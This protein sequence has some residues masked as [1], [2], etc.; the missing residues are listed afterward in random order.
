MESFRDIVRARGLARISWMRQHVP[1][2]IRGMVVLSVGLL[3]L[4]GRSIAASET[5]LYSF[6]GGADGS[7]PL[8]GLATD[9]TGTLYGVTPEGG[10]GTACNLSEG[11]GTAFTLTP[12]V[13]SGGVWTEAVI[14][15][16]AGVFGADGFY[17][18]GVP[19]V[20]DGG[21]YGATLQGGTTNNWG[22]AFRLQRPAISGGVWNERI[23]RS[24]SQ[25]GGNTPYDGLLA[26]KNGTLY[27]AGNGGMTVYSAVFQ[28]TPPVGGA[29]PWSPTV[30]YSFIGGTK[31][32]AY[33]TGPVVADANGVL[34]GATTTYSG[35]VNGCGLVYSLTPP[36]VTGGTWTESIVYS[37][38]GGTDGCNPIDKLTVAPDGTLYGVTATG[39]ASN[40]GTVYQLTPS[41]VAGGRGPRALFIASPGTRTA[42]LRTAA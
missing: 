18:L 29:G 26:D 6:Q 5:V 21:V 24:F 16:F 36:V 17:P 39:G 30:L 33:V 41:A 2:V 35:L 34:Y 23:L 25:L 4:S 19:L 7:H 28:L 9:S 1:G 13:I 22:T 20:R 8:T 31:D 38:L 40:L 15:T 27:L 3:A 11:C 42:P 14:H 10:S 37:F 32:G 12:P